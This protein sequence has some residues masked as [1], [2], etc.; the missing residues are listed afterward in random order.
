[1]QNGKLL[2]TGFNPVE[3]DNVRKYAI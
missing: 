3:I 2:E 1:M